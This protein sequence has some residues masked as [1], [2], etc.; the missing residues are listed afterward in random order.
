MSHHRIVAL[1]LVILSC[2]QTSVAQDTLTLGK[3]LVVA[4]DSGKTRS[5]S[6][7]LDDGDYVVGSITQER[8][9]DLTLMNPKRILI[10]RTPGASR[11]GTMRFAF[12]A[13]GTGAHSVD[14]TNPGTQT[15][16][17]DV[18][19]DNIVS[20]DERLRPAPWRD[21]LTSPRI[22]ALRTEIA[23]GQP[24]DAFWKEMAQQGTPLVEPFGSDGKYQLVTFLWRAV[25]A[26]RNVLVNGSFEDPVSIQDLA[27]HRLGT[28][29]VW[30]LTTK[31]P[32]GSRFEYR[33]SPN[34]P[35]TW[36]E[37][38]SAER[39]AT[40]QSDPLNPRRLAA[41][42]MVSCPP[43]APNL[44][45]KSVTELPHAVPQPWTIA[46]PATPKGQVA[47]HTI[48]SAIQK[49]DRPFSVYTPANYRAA[50]PPNALLILFDG[51]MYL[52]FNSSY[53]YDTE[54]FQML[55]TL[56]EL[57]AASKIPPTVV[58]F[59][60]NVG[61][62]RMVDLTANPEFADFVATELV[63]WVRAHY[64]VTKDASRVVVG[65]YSASGLA[66]AYVGLRHSEVFGNVISQSGAFWW[67]PDH[68]AGFCTSMCQ[69]SGYVA[70]TWRDATTEGN[71]IG[72]QFLLGPKLPLRFHLDAGT[73]EVDR[74]G[75][76]GG[77][78]LEPT[79]ALRDILRSK[80]Y[81]VHYQQ[82]HGGH[83]GLSWRGTIADALI[84]L[85]GS[86][87]PESGR[88]PRDVFR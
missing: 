81:D 54:S 6:I 9:V 73:L 28:S 77:D 15:T 33:L 41:F 74:Y 1:F 47:L 49:L 59:V 34:D 69:D 24:T 39:N 21:T 4:L 60:N 31:L 88:P 5:L 30:Y 44:I 11:S 36:D 75:K 43:T 2:A 76:G 63:P 42:A 25:N 83:D 50:G 46:K 32:S 48:T 52:H 7:R 29:D 67:A 85:L 53:W 78:I 38:R 18:V 26:T 84:A 58:V 56:N 82:F 8:R 55:T 62:R 12:V 22:E 23:T 57:I 14:I 86:R 51:P 35:M 79:R 68:N 27:M 72:K 16:R 71:W 80:G 65:G 70:R 66:A 45:C 17:V 37:S 3:P 64:N 13:E 19:V 20:L 87:Q 10:R 40:L 61:N